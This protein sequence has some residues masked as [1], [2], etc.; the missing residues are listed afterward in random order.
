MGDG[1]D[2]GLQAGVQEKDDDVFAASFSII[3]WISESFLLERR[4]AFLYE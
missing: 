1:I 3:V 2:V 4:G